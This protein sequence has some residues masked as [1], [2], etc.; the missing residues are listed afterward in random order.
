MSKTM[1]T[2]KLEGMG[3]LFPEDG[4]GVGFRVWAPGAE[5]VAVL[6]D[7]QS[8]DRDNPLQLDQEDDGFWYGFGSQAEVGQEYKILIHNQGRALERIDPYARQVTHSAGNGVIYNPRSFQWEEGDYSLPALN[9]LVIYELHLGTFAHDFDSAIERLSYLKGLGV[10]AVEVMP[11]AEF[12]G[13][14]SWGYNPAHIFSVETSYGGVDGFK[15]FVQEAHKAGIGVILDLVYNHLGPNDLDLWNFDGSTPEGKG[16]P[17]F[18]EDDRACTPWGDTRPDY[19]H[20]VV[21][22]YLM[23]NFLMWLQE[24]RI[25]GVRTDGTVYIRKKGHDQG[26][27]P[28]GWSLLQWF[29]EVAA[30]QTPPRLMIAEDMQDEE[31]LTKP[32]SEGGAGFDCQ[33]DS[34]FCS[35]VRQML[36]SASDDSRD[37][38]R[39][40]EAMQ[41]TFNGNFYQSILFLENHDEVANGQ[42]RL[43]T[44]IDGENAQADY[45]R[46][47]ALLGMAVVLTTPGIPMLF[48]GQERLKSGWFHDEDYIDWERDEEIAEELSIVR[49]LIALRS[50]RDDRAPGLLSSRLEVL[51]AAEDSGVLMIRR[52]EGE[53]ANV[54]VYNLR[55]Q[56][57]RVGL[58]DQMEVL[59]ATGG[60]DVTDGELVLQPYVAVVLDRVRPR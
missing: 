51:S 17:Y 4:K 60:A 37:P 6:G 40:V 15:R 57:N 23:D 30:Q 3:A 53:K 5:K 32:V 14:K 46:A 12:P 16:G 8:W 1:A 29:N 20:P 50:G 25:D 42:A 2:K 35:E 59:A 28:D 43:T 56:Q 45:V 34:Q 55:N 26:D 58:P 18:Y 11:I 48:Q 47:R 39:L 52:G 36:S 9:Q 31:W 19:G 54:V 33:W 44:E 49:S 21:R 38:R 41:H 24:Y 27:I 22:Q 10:N 7:W 13:D